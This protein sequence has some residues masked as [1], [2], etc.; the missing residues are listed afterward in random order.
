MKPS[1]SLI[2]NNLASCAGSLLYAHI[3]QACT[4]ALSGM[5]SSGAP[6]AVRKVESQHS[7]VIHSIVVCHHNAA[8]FAVLA[9][10]AGVQIWD[11]SVT[12]LL[13]VAP[14]PPAAAAGA[15]G[16]APRHG[17]FARGAAI[18]VAADGTPHIAFGTSAGAVFLLELN[19]A[20]GKFRGLPVPLPPHHTSPITAIGSPYQSRQG[21]WSEDLGCYLVTCDEDG[22]VAVWEAGN[23]GPGGCQL[24]TSVAP[25]GVPVVSVAVRRDIVVAARLDG[26]VQLYGLRDGKLRAD[27]GAHSR[28]ISAMDIHPTKDIIATVSEDCSLGVWALPIGGA[29]ADCLLSVCWMHA[30]L[31]GV[32]FCGAAGDDV[33]VVAYD[34]DE[35]H[36]YKYT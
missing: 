7:D 24:V 33:A 3:R 2:Y 29:K 28:F 36:V 21:K 1:P 35:V 20:E 23:T 4:F 34:T 22:G 11:K 17:A 5:S 10:E 13:H 12:H 15:P 32:A 9:T 30:A 8:A 16:L 25:T 27:L 19:E 6:V 18:N 14:L 26:A 31:T